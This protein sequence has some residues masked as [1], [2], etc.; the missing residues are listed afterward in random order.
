M[1]PFH[2]RVADESDDGDDD[3][4]DEEVLVGGVGA[5]AAAA[6]CGSPARVSGRQGYSKQYVSGKTP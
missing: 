4:E 2:L 6:A 3:G 5:A 1:V